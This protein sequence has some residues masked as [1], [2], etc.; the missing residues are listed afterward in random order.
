VFNRDRKSRRHVERKD[1]WQ[2]VC[3]VIKLLA[4]DQR[5][6]R[7]SARCVSPLASIH[8]SHSIDR[9]RFQSSYLLR[10]R[11][12]H[13]S[14]LYHASVAWH[15]HFTLT[16]ESQAQGCLC[17]SADGAADTVNLGEG[18]IFIFSFIRVFVLA[19]VQIPLD[20][21][22]PTLSETRASDKVRWVRT[23]LRQVRG[24]CLIG[25]GPVW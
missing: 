21:T 7:C 23:G 6:V 24:L 11:R 17:I 10:S 19:K 5:C 3:A 4:I 9:R 2:D 16:N 15:F 22:H 18:Y 8:F 14:R 13:L 20:G 1:V 25:S 12:L